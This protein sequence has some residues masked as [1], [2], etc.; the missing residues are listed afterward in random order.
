MVTECGALAPG[1]K[2]GAACAICRK[3]AYLSLG[4][5]KWGKSEAPSYKLP[6]LLCDDFFQLCSSNF[7]TDRSQVLFVLLLRY[8]TPQARTCSGLVLSR[9][10]Q[11]RRGVERRR[12]GLYMRR[13]R[14]G[15][16]EIGIYVAETR[17]LLA[18]T[19][20]HCRLLIHRNRNHCCGWGVAPPQ[21][22][23]AGEFPSVLFIRH[24]RG[25]YLQ[26]RS[27][28]GGPSQECA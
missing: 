1:T 15:G 22:H 20:S 16:L 18:S 26:L 8:Q 2:L 5:I 25:G 19:P 6:L 27:R 4:S 12:V 9:H 28:G 23:R 17:G 3:L 21:C 10:P 14:C 13:S 7:S 24:T 11:W